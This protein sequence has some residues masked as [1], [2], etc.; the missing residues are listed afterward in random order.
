MTDSEKRYSIAELFGWKWYRIPGIPSD[1]GRKYRCLFMPCMVESDGILPRGYELADMTEAICNDKYITREGLVPD[2][3]KDLNAAKDLVT[4]LGKEGWFCVANSGLDGT[5]EC[6]FTKRTGSLEEDKYRI[7]PQ[8]GDHYGAGDTL[9]IALCE[10]FLRVK[11][12]WIDEDDDATKWAKHIVHEA[13]EKSL[14]AGYSHKEKK[15]D[16]LFG[17]DE[18]AD[19]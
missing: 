13:S 17:Y 11:R 5:W 16:R 18:N 19:W 8:E 2:Y 1:G 7:I 12:K 10:A 9:A 4:M 6:F 14:K 15:S 3:L